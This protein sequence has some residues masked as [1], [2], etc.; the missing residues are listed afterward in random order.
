MTGPV[1]VRALESAVY[2][3]GKPRHALRKGFAQI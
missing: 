1:P 2:R 3:Y